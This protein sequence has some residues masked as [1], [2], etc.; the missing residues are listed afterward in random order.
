MADVSGVDVYLQYP[1]SS[2]TQ[3]RRLHVEDIRIVPGRNP[4]VIP[5][6]MINKNSSGEPASFVL[7]LG[8]MSESVL[9]TGVIYDEDAEPGADTD[10]I[11]TGGTWMAWPEVERVFRTSWRYYEMGSPPSGYA[12]LRLWMD[13][14]QTA[15]G[16]LF[17]QLTV[18][19]DEAKPY[20]TFDM[21]LDLVTWD[22]S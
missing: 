7:D 22:W 8:M 15:Y 1:S 11:D 10:A 12:I 2:G 21:K 13:Q 14:S 6:P 16:V 5:L 3:T 17:S 19:R 9:L 20:W 18:R 4:S